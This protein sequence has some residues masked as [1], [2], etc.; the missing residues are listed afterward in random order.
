MQWVLPARFPG[1]IGWLGFPCSS[2]TERAGSGLFTDMD[3]APFTEE[4][5]RQ[6]AVVIP[7]VIKYAEEHGVEIPPEFL[8]LA[9]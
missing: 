6:D 4:A 8:A 7:N 2:R 9:Q 5:K 3:Q 1:T